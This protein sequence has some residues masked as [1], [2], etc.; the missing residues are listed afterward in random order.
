MIY[1]PGP[2]IRSDQD[3]TKADRAARGLYTTPR[4]GHPLEGPNR[5]IASLHIMQNFQPCVRRHACLPGRRGIARGEAALPEQP[6]RRVPPSQ[7]AEGGSSAVLCSYVYV[8]VARACM[9]YVVRKTLLLAKPASVCSEVS[10][11]SPHVLQR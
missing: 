5:T 11:H 7:A 8:W 10:S 6:T 4:P 3:R 9:F 2:Q 1:Q